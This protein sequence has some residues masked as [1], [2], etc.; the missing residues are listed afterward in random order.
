MIR[1]KGIVLK[2]LKYKESSL[3][4][5]IFTEDLGLH[6]FLINGVFKKGDQRL[7]AI[8]SVGN[9]IDLIAYFSEQKNLHRLKEV[10][11][12]Y[13]YNDLYYNLIKSAISTFILEI[14]RKTIKDHHPNP[15]LFQFIQRCLIILD[16]QEIVDSDFHLKFLI[17]LTKILGFQ[18]ENN[19][20]DSNNAFDLENGQ[21]CSYLIQSP[22]HLE[23]VLSQY[24]HLLLSETDAQQTL[25]IKL[26]N[27]HRRKLL[28]GILLYYRIHIENFGLLNSPDIF[29]SIL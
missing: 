16:K 17:R 2:A 19:F 18:P 8:L 5:D 3:I 11:Y 28:D 26:N 22:Y 29:K 4:L 15:E 10:N 6:S 7:A 12:A 9:I 20:S 14:C 23:P 1:T 27:L 24:M 13:V 21:F 25:P